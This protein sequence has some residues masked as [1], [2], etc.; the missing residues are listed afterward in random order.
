MSIAGVDATVDQRI[1]QCRTAFQTLM[2]LQL[3]PGCG[4]VAYP[5]DKGELGGVETAG[6]LGRTPVGVA[7]ADLIGGEIGLWLRTSQVQVLVADVILAVRRAGVAVMYQSA[8][9]V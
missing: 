4:G 1:N 5:V 9:E 2:N 7:L 8:L 3:E 6:D